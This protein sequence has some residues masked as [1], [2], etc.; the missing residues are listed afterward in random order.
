MHTLRYHTNQMQFIIFKLKAKHLQQLHFL[1]SLE[2]HPSVTDYARSSLNIICHL[3]VRAFRLTDQPSWSS[4]NFQH[5]PPSLQ[6]WTACYFNA[7]EDLQSLNSLF[8]MTAV[9]AALNYIMH[10][11]SS[12]SKQSTVVRHSPQNQ[13]QKHT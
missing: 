12:L 7:K 10:L 5:Q 8:S 13:T 2:C 11:L 9:I 4:G 6:R 1:P 3:S